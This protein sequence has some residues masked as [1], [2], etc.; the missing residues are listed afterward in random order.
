MENYSG[1][2]DYFDFK[3]ENIHRPQYEDSPNANLHDNL[4]VADLVRVEMRHLIDPHWYSFPP[5]T[6]TWYCVLVAFISGAGVLAVAGNLLVIC[7]FV[8][9][10]TLRTPS[11]YFVINLALSDL[12]SVIC[13]CP[14]VVIN[15]YY[16][17]WVFGPTLC[18]IYGA[19]GSLTGSA[20][21]F[22]MCLISRDRFL[23]IV[24]V[25]H[26]MRKIFY[27][28]FCCTKLLSI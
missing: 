25:S 22:T 5:M 12:L 19:I 24:K 17:S 8:G 27:S 11:N 4:T 15:S 6:D 16:K 1:N 14:P 23:V 2:I 28:I 3:E 20:S 18:Q 9:S 21:I 13:M 10:K 26:A 7:T